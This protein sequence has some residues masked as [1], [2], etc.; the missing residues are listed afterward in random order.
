MT[1]LREGTG[2]ADTLV[3]IDLD[4]SSS[5]PG[6]LLSRRGWGGRAGTTSD[7]NLLILPSQFKAKPHKCLHLT[8]R[9]FLTL[10]AV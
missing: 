7:Q 8:H 9:G 3:P 10:V 1:V 2:L 5:P 4:G 6:N